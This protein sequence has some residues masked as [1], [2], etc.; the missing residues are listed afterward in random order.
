MKIFNLLFI[1]FI[2]SSAI[3][4]P[5][6]PTGKRWVKVGNMSDD[7]E[8]GFKTS[9]WVKNSPTWIGRPPGLF[10]TVNV[11]VSD[12][13]LKI[14][15]KKLDRV[16][17][18]KGKRFTHGGGLVRSKIGIN[19]ANTAGGVYF[20]TKMKANETF[21]SSTFWT[22]TEESGS[23]PK[24]NAEVD[25]QECVGIAIRRSPRFGHDFD[26]H[27]H[28]NSHDHCKNPSSTND[29]KDKKRIGPVTDWITYGAWVTQNNVRIYVNGDHQYTIPHN[30]APINVPLYLRMVTETYDWNPPR[31][32][33]DGMDLSKS[34]RTTKYKFMNTYRLV[35]NRATS[36]VN[37]RSTSIST[38]EKTNSDLTIYPNP[39]S[40]SM[41]DLNMSS[42]NTSEEIYVSLRDVNGIQLFSKSFAANSL[43]RLPIK[44]DISQVKTISN[45][46]YFIHIQNGNIK[47]TQKL[48]IQRN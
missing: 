1:L 27:I 14:L 31:P 39:V 43:D 42:L 24:K 3:A 47:E 37:N 41:I 19:P 20:E 36:L 46:V 21:M 23:C 44:L 45:G 8:N 15:A 6:P 29:N 32:G 25:F 18:R 26:N 48:I 5:P 40:G 35:N 11:S 12:G 10:Q 22:R 33:S 30:D 2:I 4:Q 38:T 7:F 13:E 17:M 9:K 34:K 28:S 16:V